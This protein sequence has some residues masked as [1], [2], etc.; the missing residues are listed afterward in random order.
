MDVFVYNMKIYTKC[1]AA[2]EP[3]FVKKIE[4]KEKA[5]ENAH[6]YRNGQTLLIA[7]YFSVYS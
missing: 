5:I 2:G 7:A 3:S 1:L 4:G 6:V